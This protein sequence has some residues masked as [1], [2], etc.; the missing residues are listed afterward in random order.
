MAH[1]RRQHFDVGRGIAHSQADPA[2]QLN[3]DDAVV[4][5]VS[6]A[7][8]VKERPEHQQVGALDAIGNSRGFGCRLEQMT[9]DCEPVIGVALRAT[10]V[11]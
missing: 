7:D 8:V 11:R 9:V 5:G 3:S 1:Q 4:A 6:L 10:S 2:N